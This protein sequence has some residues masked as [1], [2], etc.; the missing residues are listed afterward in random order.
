MLLK[1]I[2]PDSQVL[3]RVDLNCAILGQHLDTPHM[4][5]HLKM[6]LCE[7]LPSMTGDTIR[8]P[9]AYPNLSLA[10][11]L[12]MYLPEEHRLDMIQH[13]HSRGKDICA[14]LYVKSADGDENINGCKKAFPSA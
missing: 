8:I 14:N 1:V 2:R 7:V 9:K 5:P 10:G 12:R 11:E 4:S 6:F 13:P 3:T